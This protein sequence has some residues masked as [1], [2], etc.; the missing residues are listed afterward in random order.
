MGLKSPTLKPPEG[1]LF[2]LDYTPAQL[3]DIETAVAR[4][5]YELL[6]SLTIYGG[7]LGDTHGAA[8]GIALTRYEGPAAYNLA[9][10]PYPLTT[11]FE[12][13]PYADAAADAPLLCFPRAMGVECEMNPFVSVPVE[14]GPNCTSIA[15]DVSMHM[16]VADPCI[17]KTLAGVA[18]G[19]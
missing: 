2:F 5:Q 6:E 15:C 17:A 11:W 9:G 1:A 12:T 10:I 4:W 13:F 7:Y 19:C 14:T 18:G 16:H 3:A 8:E